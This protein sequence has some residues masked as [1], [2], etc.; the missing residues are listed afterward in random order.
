MWETD[1]SSFNCSPTAENAC[2]YQV[3][4]GLSSLS[5][6]W[7]FVVSSKPFS[8]SNSNI[9]GRLLHPHAWPYTQE[10]A[11]HIWSS[12][13]L[14]LRCCSVTAKT[15]ERGSLEVHNLANCQTTWLTVAENSLKY[16]HRTIIYR[17][18]SGQGIRATAAF[19]SIF[20]FKAISPVKDFINDLKEIF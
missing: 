19:P 20:C 18:I 4:S 10:N 12:F 17:G 2:F 13:V 3:T 6:K 9:C 14:L 15:F 16:E 1:F 8:I 5:D 11:L 7:F